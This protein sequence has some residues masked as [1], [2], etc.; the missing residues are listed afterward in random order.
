[1]G[2]GA[3]R[4][5]GVWA[6]L[7]RTASPQE[8]PEAGGARGKRSGNWPPPPPPHR[9]NVGR[10]S[11]G[12][13]SSAARVGEARSRG[14]RSPPPRR[15]RARTREQSAARAVAMGEGR[16][17]KARAR[18]EPNAAEGGRGGRRARASARA[19]S[20][21]R[22]CARRPGPFSARFG[23][24]PGAAAPP[25]P[26]SRAPSPSH[27]PPPPP[28][29]SEGERCCRRCRCLSSR[30][31]RGLELP[32]RLAGPPACLSRDR[33]LLASSGAA[34]G[35]DCATRTP[36]GPRCTSA[37]PTKRVST[38]PRARRRARREP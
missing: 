34:A 32:P 18:R 36:P 21:E 27:P 7:R 3:A 29:A 6:A 10:G 23:L 19:R 31:P 15:E 28:A 30:V 37:R 16:A 11:R 24:A 4:R 5:P 1:M 8:G 12:K 2:E 38:H 13:A 26:G 35:S 33:R 22:A 14:A 17:V 20:G 9:Q 25:P